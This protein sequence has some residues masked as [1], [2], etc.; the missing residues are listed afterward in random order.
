MTLQEAQQKLATRYITMAD[1]IIDIVKNG[2]AERVLNAVDELLS[3]QK[4]ITQVEE[5]EKV[6]EIVQ[7]LGYEFEWKPDGIHW[8][9]IPPPTL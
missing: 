3:A 6:Q 5:R 4:I 1:L 9:K 8:K 2:R 7:L